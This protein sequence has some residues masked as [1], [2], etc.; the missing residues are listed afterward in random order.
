VEVRG[1]YEA[2]PNNMPRFVRVEHAKIIKR[3]PIQKKLPSVD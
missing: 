2:G 3:P 1:E